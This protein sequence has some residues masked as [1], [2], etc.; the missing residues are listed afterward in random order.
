MAPCAPTQA[1][2]FLV[3]KSKHFLCSHQTFLV[4]TSK[5]V[6]CS[7]KSPVFKSNR[8]FLC[9]NQDMSRVSSR[10]FRV[11]QAKHRDRY[12]NRTENFKRPKNREDSSDLDE[13]L[14]ETI[15]AM[16]SIISKI[17]RGLGPPR[18]VEEVI[19]H[20]IPNPGEGLPLP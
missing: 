15:A 11:P 13:N 1:R 5:H 3:R 10:T 2:T 7:K 18:R 4:F 8:R 17:R 6:V 9:S 14:T 16:R 12:S 19:D 20:P